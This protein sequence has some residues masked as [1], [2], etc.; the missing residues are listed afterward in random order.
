MVNGN[1]NLP[2]PDSE[3]TFYIYLTIL[4]FLEYRVCF[5][6]Q[7]SLKNASGSSIIGMRMLTDDQK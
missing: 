7:K 1:D 2:H 4:S 3:P 5:S 6:C